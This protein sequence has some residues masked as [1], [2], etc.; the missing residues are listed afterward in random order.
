MVFVK[1]SK[2]KKSLPG[3][4]AFPSGTVEAGED[5]QKTVMREANEELGIEVVPERIIAIKE[6]PEF[7]S[8]LHFIVCALVEGTPFIK[9]SN[10]IDEMEWLTLL[11][12]FKKYDDTQIGHGLIFLRQHPE[13]WKEYA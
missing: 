4:W 7:G 1:R 12:F 9:D 10:E 8:T 6:L 5:I 2:L 11:Q 13:V 3:I